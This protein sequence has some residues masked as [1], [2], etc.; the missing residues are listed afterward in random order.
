MSYLI[1]TNIIAEVRKG[2]RCHPQV[3]RWWA[4]VT[5]D[6]LFLSVLVLGE[7]R[8]GIELVRPHDSAKAL[9]LEQ[10]LGSVIAAFVG[11]ILPVDQAVADE[12][13][14]M[15][16][17]RSRPTIDSFLAATAKV[18][19]LTLATRNVADVQNAGARVLNPFLYK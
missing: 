11:R 17:P 15:N 2:S 18:Y 16:A 6:E 8:K 7:I 1:D 14:R 4:G 9:A 3:A 13:G 12:W 19:D 5:D 10:W